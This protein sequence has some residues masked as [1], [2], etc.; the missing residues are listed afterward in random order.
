MKNIKKIFYENLEKSNEI[1]FNEFSEGFDEFLKTGWYILGENVK[2][3]ELDFSSFNN[4]KYTIGVASGLDA[5][6]LSIS[7]LN[8]EKGSEIIVPSNTYIATILAIINNGHIPVFVE[9]DILTYNIDPKK[10]ENKISINTK[11]ILIVHLYGKSCEMDSIKEIVEKHSLFLIEDC[12]QAHGAKFKGDTV[13]NFGDFG[14]FSF[15][16]TKNLGALGDAGAITTNSLLNNEKIRRL[17]NYGSDVK[18]QNDVLGFNSRLDEIQ[19]YFLKIKLRSLNLITDH[20]RKLAKIYFDNLSNEFIKPVLDDDYYDV[21]HIYN[22]R[23]ENR[24]KIRENLLKNA[25]HTEIHYPVA[26]HKQKA[27]KEFSNIINNDF[28]ISEEIH[29]T[30]LSLPISFGTTEEEVFRVCESLNRI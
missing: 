5:L 14:A 15:Y 9:P 12:A 4:S 25:I 23:H 10:I 8:L 7:S 20:K 16:P 26:P 13:G 24:D 1:F 17:R 22:I 27:L 30:T 19:A 11:A 2:Q 18:Y 21:F 28:L 6:H 29:N 3:F